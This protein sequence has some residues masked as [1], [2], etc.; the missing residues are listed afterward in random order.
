MK[1]NLVMHVLVKWKVC[2][3]FQLTHALQLAA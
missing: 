1:L 2:E 3:D